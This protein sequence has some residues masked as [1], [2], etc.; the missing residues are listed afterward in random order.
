LKDLSRFNCF[1]WTEGWKKAESV[2]YDTSMMYNWVGNISKG[3]IV[4]DIQPFLNLIALDRLECTLQ[5]HE[6]PQPD[7]VKILQIR[8]EF[9]PWKVVEF[10]VRTNDETTPQ[11]WDEANWDEVNANMEMV[12]RCLTEGIVAKV[13]N[14]SIGEDSY[15]TK[16]TGHR[17]I[18]KREALTETDKLYSILA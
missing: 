2:G 4:D 10:A 11:G 14:S 8:R 9:C 12:K 3:K 18:V 6:L 1:T 7:P 17:L 5:G 13:E 16:D 15:E